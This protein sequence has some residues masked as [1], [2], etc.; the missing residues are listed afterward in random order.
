MVHKHLKRRRTNLLNM[1]EL[2]CYPSEPAVNRS[3]HFFRRSTVEGQARE[4]WIVELMKRD[5]G[6][7]S[8][9]IEHGRRSARIALSHHAPWLDETEPPA[10][11]WDARIVDEYRRLVT[12]RLAEGFTFDRS[13]V[14]SDQLFECGEHF[15]TIKYKHKVLLRTLITKKPETAPGG[16]KV[17]VCAKKPD[18][19]K[20]RVVLDE[21]DH[22]AS[23]D[24][25]LLEVIEYDSDAEPDATTEIQGDTCH[26]QPLTANELFDDSDED[27]MYDF[28]DE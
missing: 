6:D 22:D 13:T 21:D 10:D 5:N 25:D 12:G 3:D 7:R 18:L 2:A 11:G 24:E 9:M 14:H 27:G 26:D 28:D 17:K 23:D 8:L 20:A 15:E 1:S 19:H 4:V 16:R